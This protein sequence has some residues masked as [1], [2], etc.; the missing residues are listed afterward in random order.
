MKISSCTLTLSFMLSLLIC[1]P[2]LAQKVE[3]GDNSV[4][5]KDDPDCINRIHPAIP[6][7]KQANPGDTIV[8][9]SRNAVCTMTWPGL[10]SSVSIEK[11]GCHFKNL[12]QSSHGERSIAR[13]A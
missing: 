8:F 12:N 4:L 6:M 5:C 9:N 1:P 13:L 11:Q 2:L 10:C 7:L 3:V